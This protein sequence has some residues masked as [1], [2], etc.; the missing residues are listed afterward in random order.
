[1]KTSRIAWLVAPFVLTAASAWA[2]PPKLS[3]KAKPQVQLSPKLLKL[4]SM[5]GLVAGAKKIPPAA[6][7][8]KAAKAQQMG[9]PPANLGTPLSAFCRPLAGP[10]A[11][12]SQQLRPHVLPGSRSVPGHQ[13]PAAGGAVPVSPESH[14]EQALPGR[15]RGT[16]KRRLVDRSAQDA[17]TR[18]AAGG[19]TV[20][21][22]Q[23]N[24]SHRVG[25][26][27][28]IALGRFALPRSDGAVCL[29]HQL[30]RDHSSAMRARAS[31]L[32]AAGSK[33]GS[34]AKCASQ[35]PWARS[36]PHGSGTPRHQ[37][38]AACSTSRSAARRRDGAR[39]PSLRARLETRRELQTVPNGGNANPNLRPAHAAAAHQRIEQSN[40]ESRQRGRGRLNTVE[41]R[42]SAALVRTGFGGPAEQG[43][44][45]AQRHSATP[46]RVARRAEPGSSSGA[47]TSAGGKL[48]Q[49]RQ[50]AARAARRR[51]K[52]RPEAGPRARV[53]WSPSSRAR[54]GRLRQGALLGRAQ[55]RGRSPDIGGLP[56]G[57]RRL[58]GTT[59]ASTWK[60]ASAQERPPKRGGG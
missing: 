17:G 5:D 27:D 10:R 37:H 23:R 59:C 7:K 53:S 40:A 57:S 56:Q 34:S 25:G 44:P 35:A 19:V 42:G 22:P 14:A 4:K 38:R 50:R 36:S 51:R 18:Q 52:A 6:M 2:V 30:L 47:S 55:G 24:V 49:V 12:L 43:Q 29:G 54:V 3:Y 9:V 32:R 8:S 41:L 31:S 16:G 48:A 11:R 13:R 45:P 15:V 28:T 20:R 46:R 1:M 33:D 60:T 26:A 58:A 21:R 39:R